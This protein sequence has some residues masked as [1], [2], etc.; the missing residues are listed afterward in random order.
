M[1]NAPPA[2]PYGLLHPNIRVNPYAAYARLR[3]EAPVHFSEALG[4]WI[5]TRY[6]DVHAAFRDAR[7]SSKRPTRFA[8]QWMEQMRDAIGPMVRNMSAWVLMMDPPDHTRIRSLI[9]RAFT[10]RMVEFLRPRIQ[11]LADGLLDAAAKDGPIDLMRDFA[12][13]LPV[14][15]IGEMLGLPA[16]DRHRLKAWS[17]GILTV[18]ARMPTLEQVRAMAQ[19]F[20][21]IEVYMRDVIAER[22]KHPGQDLISELL[23][24]EEQG[25]F[26]S[27]QEVLST[28][29]MLLFAGHETTTNLIGNGTYAL[30][31]QPDQLQVLRDSPEVLPT[32]VEELLRFDSPVQRMARV[33]KEELELGGQRV[34]QGDILF[35]N[36]GAANRDPEQFPNPDALDVRREDNRHVAFG[37]GI[38]YCVGAPLGRL[39]GELAL[40]TLLR[41]FPRLEL[42]GEVVWRDNLTLRGLESLPVR[43]AP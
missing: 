36:I 34:R 14:L 30:L 38:H 18:G 39:E 22:R 16:E 37:L 31:R 29:T 6:A 27:E 41:R 42:A 13:P 32:A 9:N 7:L 1:Q 19:A 8:P 4:G 15:V 17:N 23:A 2:D 33:A 11:G 10:P 35:L 3:A 12:V 26:L 20:T 43:L 40:G 5:L 28:C 21:E 25:K 24:A